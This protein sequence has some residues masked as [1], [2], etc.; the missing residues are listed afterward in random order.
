MIKEPLTTLCDLM[1]KYTRLRMNHSH[2]VAIMVA[3]QRTGKV[4]DDWLSQMRTL[5]ESPASRAVVD[6]TEV[7]LSYVQTASEDTL[8]R[9]ISESIKRE[10]DPSN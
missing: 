2:L 10:D 7:L 8:M 3:A 4:P 5:S 1:R 9:F 6:E